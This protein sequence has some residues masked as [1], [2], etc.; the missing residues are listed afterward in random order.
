MEQ[1]RDKTNQRGIKIRNADALQRLREQAKRA[2]TRAA[3]QAPIS[4]RKA[5]R[6]TAPR[7]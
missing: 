5:L 2:R 7:G 6:R 1:K 3:G 4:M